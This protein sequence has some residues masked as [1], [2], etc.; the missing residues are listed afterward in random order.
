MFQ[1]ELYFLM[2]QYFFIQLT[3]KTE[4]ISI[5]VTRLEQK[6]TLHQ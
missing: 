4:Q 5:Q 2:S 3:N 1:T 6:M